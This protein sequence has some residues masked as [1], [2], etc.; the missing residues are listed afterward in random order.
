MSFS[1]TVVRVVG[2]VALLAGLAGCAVE[3]ATQGVLDAYRLAS[4]AQQQDERRLSPKGI[5]LRVQ[6]D[7]H[8]AF[9]AL[10]Y[11]DQH[12]D[13]PVH[14]WYSAEREV[15]R[16]RDGR[17]VGTAF[18]SGTNWL[19]VSFAQLPSWDS[20][21][22]QAAFERVRDVSPGYRYGIREKMLIRRIAA[23]D[24]T[25][26]RLVPAASLVWFEETVQGETDIPP[27]RYAVAKD[28]R[29]G[30]P[31]VVYAEQCLSGD[32][33]FSWQRW[34]TPGKGVQ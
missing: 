10:G 26:L 12:S 17:V 28:E 6:V 14:V 25:Q 21:G 33:C 5:Y 31:R 2:V 34:P 30:S 15:L 20:L 11:I 7:R 22:E 9:L 23:P 29:D 3:S 32:M 4:A 19:N 13:G 16:L 1:S 27:A 18:K 24:D 8:D